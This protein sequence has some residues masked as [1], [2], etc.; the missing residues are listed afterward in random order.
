M[1]WRALGVWLVVCIGC[2]K[3]SEVPCE[4]GRICPAGF[5]CD[6][7]NH[8][9]VLAEQL[10]SCTGLDPGDTCPIADE[11]VG[12]CTNGVCVLARCGD[13]YVRGAE[14]CDGDNL[15]GKQTCVDLGYY[16]TAA[17]SCTSDCVFETAACSEYC[18]DAVINGPEFCE[19]E[20]VPANTTC[21]QFG[22][23]TG[24]LGCTKACG[25]GFDA[26]VRY[27]F[28]PVGT[29]IAGRFRA[30]W[31]ASASDIFG[32]GDDVV[33]RYNGTTWT[34]T[35]VSARLLAMS[36]TSATD[37]WAVGENRVV[38]HFDGSAWTP[39]TLPGTGHLNDVW[40][41]TPTDVYAVGSRLDAFGAALGGVIAHFNGSTWALTD[42]TQ[43]MRTVHGVA[44]NAVYA[45][46]ANGVVMYLNGSVWTE[47]A[48]G[49]PEIQS[50][51]A[52]SPDE[53]YVAA[54]S[55]LLRI[56]FAGGVPS[57]P[58][59]IT[60]PWQASYLR[61]LWG[62][63][64]RLFIGSAEG[65]GIHDGIRT[66]LVSTDGELQSLWGTS[67]DLFGVS[68]AGALLRFGGTGW[69]A[70]LL[71]TL[72]MRAIAGS[73]DYVAAA[74]PSSVHT[75]SGQSWALMPPLVETRSVSV[76]EVG[77]IYAAGGNSTGFVRRF[78]PGETGWTSASGIGTGSPW[79]GV[80]AA[81]PDIAFAVGDGKATR[82]VNMVGSPTPG[83]SSAE[84]RAVWGT[85]T[86]NAYAVGSNNGFGHILQYASTT[87]TWVPI[88]LPPNTPALW[89][90]WGTSAASFYVAGEQGF[91]A[92]W[93]GSAWEVQ[94]LGTFQHFTAIGGTGPN[95][96]FIGGSFGTL[97]HFDGT[98][99]LA[100]RTPTNRPITGIYATSRI[101]FLATGEGT[102]LLLREP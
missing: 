50:I 96:V 79:N 76:V 15:D 52:R 93:T 74:D 31:G 40:A 42:T 4:D 66:V 94:N 53:V 5:E 57:T 14:R 20:L 65:V 43:V 36:G 83:A 75:W 55:Q 58:V 12:V 24:S 68:A 99:W 88:T 34:E 2:V 82:L 84:L 102:R 73:N 37:V 18:G 3:A 86:D 49:A 60:L 8:G 63:S 21:V 64:D 9:C 48:T 81:S 70:D 16:N 44:Q 51:W 95:D 77:V 67:T 97:F 41:N 78:R 39:T 33:A 59:A 85:S 98:Q 29:S 17:I 23:D 80:W 72:Q 62:T 30:V 92:R 89:A 69:L 56:S 13:G 35:P 91:V 25:P 22:Y 10:T 54:F 87:G 28:V 100:V 38:L 46:G 26:C 7:A 90:I 101:V 45:G 27:G 61:S 19:D 32:A 11:D 47:L 71:G 1:G 6:N